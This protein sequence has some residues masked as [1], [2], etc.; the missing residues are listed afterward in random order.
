MAFLS[1][2]WLVGLLPW[3]ALVMWLFRGRRRRVRV[4]FL[5]LWRGPIPLEIPKSG[6][7]APPIWVIATLIAILAAILAA[8][9]PLI[10]LTTRRSQPIT[11][12]VDRGLTMSARR[13]GVTQFS[14]AAQELSEALRSRLSTSAPVDLLTVPGEWKSTSIGQWAALVEGALPTALDTRDSL[15]RGIRERL[16]SNEG[17][18]FV[19]SDL[20]LGIDDRRVAQFAPN[21]Q[22]KNVGII[23]VAVRATPTP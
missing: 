16:E 6:W 17:P 23:R 18:V 22:I 10:R 3:A 5:S 20:S 12:I 15:R 14:G 11:I 2:W 21:G 4:P 8:A 1:A 13:E 9:R 19:L 7:E